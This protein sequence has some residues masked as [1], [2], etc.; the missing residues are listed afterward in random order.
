MAHEI[1]T[2]GR[3]ARAAFARTPAWHNLGKVL[4]DSMDLDEGFQ[5]AGLDWEV[6]LKPLYTEEDGGYREIKG[7]KVVVREDS[8]APLGIVSNGWQ[9]VQNA[10]L[11]EFIRSVVG[12]GARLESL[13]SLRGGKRVWFLLDLKRS[14]EPIKGDPVHQ[15]L[16][17][18]NGHDGVT[19]LRGLGTGVRVVCQN[20]WSAALDG[21]DGENRNKGISFRHDGTIGN[22]TEK[23]RQYIEELFKT[24]DQRKEQAEALAKMVK[25]NDSKMGAF[26]VRQLKRIQVKEEKAVK[27]ALDTLAQFQASETNTIGGMAGTGW[28]AFQTWSEYLDYRPSKR[29]SQ[30]ARWESNLFGEYARS[31]ANAWQEL[32]ALAK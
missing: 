21:S 10:G 1:D 18:G 29:D 32:L 14:Y 8:K 4:P 3:I 30:A 15:Y 5:A 2:T 7:R 17:F 20:T 16:V 26:F 12:Q 6:G 24:H 22:Y 28:A 13:G 23:A 31:K 19:K 11:K 27:A 9:P 25:M